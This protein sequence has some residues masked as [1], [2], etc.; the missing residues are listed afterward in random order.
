MREGNAHEA[1]KLSGIIC[2]QLIPYA[3]SSYYMYFPFIKGIRP[4]F[5]RVLNT[6]RKRIC[7]TACL[8]CSCLVRIACMFCKE[9]RL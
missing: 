1:L 6:I 3:W 9:N 2:R 5:S 8:Q 7:G 4:L